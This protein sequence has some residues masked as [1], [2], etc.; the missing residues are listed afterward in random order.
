MDRR[1]RAQMQIT[2]GAMWLLFAE[3]GLS[4]TYLLLGEESRALMA[5]WLVASTDSVWREGKIWTLVTSPL[6]QVE[7]LSLIFHGLILWLFVP[8]LERWWGTWRFLKFALWT[9]LAGTAAGTL[10]GLVVS[11]PSYVAGLDPFIYA[12]IVA[13]GMLY[14]DQPVQFFGVL[15]MTGRQLMIGIVVFAALFVIL[16]AEWV[17]AA[18][19]AASMGLAWILTNGRWT[20]RIWWLRRKQKKLRRHLKLVRDDDDPPPKKWMN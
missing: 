19:F 2:R 4:L 9:S 6:L 3:G 7:L 18:A 16:G 5:D 20:P 8:T 12:A 15:P 13:F 14:A 1:Y 10:A 11:G 17:L